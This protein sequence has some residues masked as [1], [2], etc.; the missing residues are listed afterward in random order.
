MMA[1]PIDFLVVDDIAA[2]LQARKV[3]GYLAG[4]ESVV[5]W[6]DGH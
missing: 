5:G 6:G 4:D 3:A 1:G 2:Q